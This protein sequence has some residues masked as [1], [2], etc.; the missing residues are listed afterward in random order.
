M[1]PGGR[2]MATARQRG[3]LLPLPSLA[4]L[5]FLP[6][7]TR[8]WARGALL[9]LMD[10]PELPEEQVTRAGSARR[11][12]GAAVVPPMNVQNRTRTPLTKEALNTLRG[13]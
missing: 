10:H 5:R 9:E 11:P 13:L 8:S 12:T 2:A 4:M 1:G 6:R 3:A 7:R